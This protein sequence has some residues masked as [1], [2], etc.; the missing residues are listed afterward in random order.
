VWKRERREKEG[1]EK[2]KMSWNVWRQKR[3]KG[4]IY[5]FDWVLCLKNTSK[6]KNSGLLKYARN[7]ELAGTFTSR[8]HKQ[9]EPTY[10]GKKKRSNLTVAGK[11]NLFL[12]V[13]AVSLVW[14]WD[15]HEMLML[16][17]LMTGQIMHLSNG[18]LTEC[19]CM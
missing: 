9:E 4:L 11:N 16:S 18:V 17:L 13:G 14:Y 7:T 3:I 8:E 6:F 5:S 15:S 12:K 1:K 19:V 2:E 10:T